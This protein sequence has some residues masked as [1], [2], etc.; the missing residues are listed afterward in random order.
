MQIVIGV[1]VVLCVWT[2]IE[3]WLNRFK[4][5]FAKHCNGCGLLF[6][7]RT[8]VYTCQDCKERGK[9]S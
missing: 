5:V 1:I 8:N 7:S 4:P 3:L 9:S 2:V 6:V